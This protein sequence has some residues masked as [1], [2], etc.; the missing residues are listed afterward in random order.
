MKNIHLIPTDKPSRL[1]KD[2]F[3]KYF[4]SIN[5]DQEQNHF[6]P[7][8]LYITSDEEIK[9]GDWYLN[10]EEKNGIKNPFYGKL[11]KANQS[12]KSVNDDYKHN[13]KKIILTTDQD[14]INDGVQAIDDEFLEW[15]VKNPSCE[16]VEIKLAEQRCH[17]GLNDWVDADENGKFPISIAGAF[18]YRK[19]YKIIIPKEENKYMLK[20]GSNAVF[21]SSTA[22]TF[23]TKQEPKPIHQQIIDAVGGACRFREIA[24]IKPKEE[25]IEEFIK[26]ASE[27]YAHNYF[28]MHETNHYKALKQGF[29]EGAKWQAKRMHSEE[30]MIEFAIW[31]YLEIGISKNKE[32]SSKELFDEW[33]EKFKKK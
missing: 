19:I 14:L 15:F 11:Y 23:S 8:N 24:K 3:G 26:E 20:G 18:C 6:K 10:I 33:F 30:D 1:F 32:R 31:L 9:E 29:E 25:T 17:L 13:L 7:H 4:I 2:D 5:I 22:I 28:N 21:S 27:Y 12:I 16:E